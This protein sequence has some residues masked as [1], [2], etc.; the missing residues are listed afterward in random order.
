MEMRLATRL[1]QFAPSD[2]D[3]RMLARH[4]LI[5]AKDFIQHARLLRGPLK[6]A[7]F[8]VNA[9]HGLKEYYAKEFDEHFQKVRDRLSAHVQDIE[10]VERIELWNSVDSSKT[11]FFAD[12]AVDIYRELEGLT[13]GHDYPG[14][15][16]YLFDELRG[17]DHESMATELLQLACAGVIITHYSDHSRR[18]LCGCY[19][20]LERY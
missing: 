10:F 17:G 18:H 19:L 14:T 20:R 8:N 12:G 2:A 3:A 4:V 11:E 7:G 13:E 5:R 15:C 16:L 6:Q 9:F 1:S